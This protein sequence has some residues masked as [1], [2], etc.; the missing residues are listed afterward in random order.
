VKFY[1]FSLENIVKTRILELV[2]NRRVRVLCRNET[3]D[4]PRAIV[5]SR[6]VL[7][8]DP[9]TVFVARSCRSSSL[10]SRL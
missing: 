9:R 1:I 2:R 6:V 3:P 10:S 7:L 5:R 4:R 8:A